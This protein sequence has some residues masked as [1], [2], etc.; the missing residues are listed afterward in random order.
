MTT[1]PL[2]TVRQRPWTHAVQYMVDTMTD[3]IVMIQFSSEQVQKWLTIMMILNV[4]LHKVHQIGFQTWLYVLEHR[5]YIKQ[6]SKNILAVA[7]YRFNWPTCILSV[8]FD[9]FPE[10]FNSYDIIIKSWHST[11]CYM[12]LKLRNNFNQK[13]SHTKKRFQFLFWYKK[14]SLKS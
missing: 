12:Y 10:Q 11:A 1:L 3:Q 6:I 7:S 9:I 14:N 5:D 13:H 2:H 4:M 8:V